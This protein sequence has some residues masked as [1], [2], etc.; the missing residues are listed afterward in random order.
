MPAAAAYT[1]T[2]QVPAAF[3][4][5]ALSHL[6]QGKNVLDWG[7]GKYLDAQ[8]WLRENRQCMCMPYDPFNLPATQNLAVLTAVSSGTISIHT[9]TCLNVL[10]VLQ[11][12]SERETLYDTI[13]NLVLPLGIP[14]LVFQVY[15]GNGT[16]IPSTDG[17]TQTNMKASSYLGE[18]HQY[19]PEQTWD[20]SKRK[21]ILVLTRKAQKCY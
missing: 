4:D 13:A 1:S 5:P 7:A 12:K 11:D 17:I 3:K 20:I 8:T 9:V 21:N 19:F 16:G 18:I 15:E 10:N 2:R 6:F 14:A